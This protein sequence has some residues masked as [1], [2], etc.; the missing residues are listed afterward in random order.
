MK[1]TELKQKKQEMF[2]TA[3]SELG[4]FFAFNSEQ[5]PEGINNLKENGILLDG[6]KLTSMGSGGYFPS[7]NYNA[8]M[9]ENKKIEK[10]YKFQL[11][12][13]KD[14][15]KDLILYELR[16]HECFYSRDIS[17]VFEILIPLGI[18]KK[19][20]EKVYNE[21]KDNENKNN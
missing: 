13:I 15:K 21:N 6:E 2:S 5:F 3:F 12:E 20:I 16:N 7:K 11:K 1:I 10:W 8:L 19:E 17:D 9:S 18:T 4:V 14:G